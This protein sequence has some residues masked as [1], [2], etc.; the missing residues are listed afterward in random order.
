MC[1][2]GCL[3]CGRSQGS[4]L[5]RGGSRSVAPPSLLHWHSFGRGSVALPTCSVGLTSAHKFPAERRHLLML[6]RQT[7]LQCKHHSTSPCKS[8]A[9]E[10]VAASP[11][12][13]EKVKGGGRLREHESMAELLSALPRLPSAG[14]YLCKC[15]QHRRG[16]AIWPPVPGTNSPKQEA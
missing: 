3:W 16:E 9:V 4:G 6:A 2:P 8:P 7:D 13:C 14:L 12:D 5:G 1:L 11:V 10:Q 15:P